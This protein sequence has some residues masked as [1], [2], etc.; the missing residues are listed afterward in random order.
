MRTLILIIL[1]GLLS[2]ICYNQVNTDITERSNVYNKKGDYYLDR[3]E[4]KKAIIFYNMAY[5]KDT[6]DYFSVLK[7]ADA[8]TKLKLFPQAEECYRIVVETNLQIGNVYKLKYALVLLANNKPDEF[9]HWIG[10]YNQVVEEEVKSENYLVSSEKRIQM[11]KDTSVVLVSNT[12]GKDTIRFK[13]KYAGYQNRKRSTIEDKQLYIVLS[14]GDEY[15]ITA[16]ETNDFNFSFQ[17]MENYKLIIQQ[18]NIKAE[19]ILND[20]KLTPQK[21]K[22]IFLNP[23]PTQ[24][25]ELKLEKGMKYQFSSGQYKITPEYLSSVNEIAGKYQVKN[26]NAVD[27]TA[28]VK[29]LQLANG[30][31]YTIKFERTIDPGESN[32]KIEISTVTMNDKAINIFGQS[33]LLI[34]PDRAAENFAIETDIKEIEKTFSPKKYTLVIDNSPLFKSEVQSAQN[35]LITLT[36]NTKK[37]DEVK[38]SNHLSAKEISIIPGTEYLL[39]LSKPD[40]KTGEPIEVIVP[41]TKGVK[42]NFT[43]LQ[44]S[45]TDYK[46][47]LAKYLL[48]REHIE[49]A[50]EEVINISILSKELEVQPGEDLSFTLLP[51]KKFGKQTTMAEVKKSSITVDDKIFEVSPDEKYT[52]NVPFDQNRKVNFQTDLEYV[53]ENFQSNAYTL[54]LDTNTFT[55]EIAVDT[56]GYGALKS[57]GW[58]SMS[59]NT[60]SIEKVAKQNQF[61]AKGVSIIPGEEYILTV[62]KTDE[63]TGKKDDI[64]IPLIRQVKYDFTSNPESPEAYKKSLKEFIESRKDLKTTDGT[65]IDITLLSKELQIEKGDEVSFSLL[66][67]KKLSK[68]T[69]TEVPGRSSLF[70]DNKLIEFTQIQK[71]SINMPLNDERQVNMQT[72]IEHLQEN[73]EPGSFNLDVDT[74]SFFSEITVD[75]TGYGDRVQKEIVKDPVFDVVTVNFDLNEHSLS[76]EVKKILQ[77]NV[78]E[79]LKTDNRLYVTIKGYT[80]PLGNAD[81]NLNLSKKRAES[82]KEFLK[83]NNIGENRIKTFSFGASQSLKEGINWED[84]DETELRKH[85]K[86]EIIIYLPK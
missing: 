3:N 64:I 73:F 76:P 65:V 31:I 14:N 39:S 11:Y 25:D 33:F 29:E 42:Y 32:K 74:M 86:V 12:Q 6:S 84:L 37:I 80:D 19:D 81:Y 18:E 83:S 24:K 2:N 4:F 35:G 47:A 5:Q 49:L 7:K 79:K 63:V 22:S 59:V 10:L 43:S 62:S 55:S 54:S 75:T 66:P 56:A 45:N 82:V 57:T 85:R 23:P 71:Y 60:D 30:E 67:V 48:G 36:V 40:T 61:T 70:L 17:P 38:A 69:T 20:N 27:L 44:E 52:I 1:F 21:Q 13:I 34:L 9:K 77:E 68:K 8:F 46:K 78:I 58:L 16:S 28:L 41:L 53:Q 72:N 26:A 50:N 15:T 51:V